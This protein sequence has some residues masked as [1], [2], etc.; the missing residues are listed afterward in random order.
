MSYLHEAASLTSATP[1]DEALPGQI[2]NSAGGFSWG[3]DHWTR[4]QR[5]L[6]LGSEG[7]TY[8]A[9]ERKHTTENVTCLRECVDEDVKRLV[10]VIVE[11]S[12]KGR[13]P[14][15]D[16]AIFALAYVVAHGDLDGRRYAL[17]HLEKVC[18][19]GTHLFTFCGLLDKMGHLNGRAKRNALGRWYTGKDTDKLAYQLVKYRQRGGWTHRDVLRIAHPRATGQIDNL[20]RW[21]VGK[22]AEDLPKIVEGYERA[23][24][25]STPLE[26]ARLIGEYGLPREAILT[27]HLN[28]PEVWQA[29]LDAGMPMTALIRNL[30][31][32]TK[33]GLLDPFSAATKQ[34]V[35]QIADGE[36]LRKSRVH[37][38]AVL[39]ALKTYA[40]GRGFRSDAS[41]SPVPKIVDALDAA[42]YES[43]GN[44]EPTG[45]RIM[46]GLDVSASMDD[47][48]IAGTNITAREAT[49]AMALVTASTEDNYACIGFSTQLVELPISSRQ[50]LDDVLKT[51]RGISFGGTDCSLPML[52]AH[53][54]GLEVDTFA[55]YTDSETWAGTMHP[56][57]A[58]T[59]YRNKSGIDAKL[60]VVGMVSNGFTIADPNDAG[61]LDVVGFDT[62]TPQ[63]IS[64]F[65]RG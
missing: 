27:K 3:V 7:G 51:M 26:S 20:L 34:V 39:F 15:N 28:E 8:Y 13:A 40:T 38:I 48:Y 25:A 30:A 11:V 17:D 45:K 60:V 63:I 57:Q 46:L 42:F 21:T 10:D 2:E 14:K 58:L 47:A 56:S 36:H 37:P 32:M 49:A 55:V 22:D 31:T 23:Q 62:A 19:I 9:T 35:T 18:R 53:D 5:F 41:W 6:I 12:D 64:D 16:P 24:V 54:M 61:M 43:F 59:R 65:S 33:I 1:Q 50:R 44:V 29:L 4:L 52:A